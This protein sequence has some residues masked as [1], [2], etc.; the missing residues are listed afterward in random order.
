MYK[1]RIKDTVATYTKWPEECTASSHSYPALRS[2]THIHRDLH[3]HVTGYSYAFDDD[4]H[5]AT[6]IREAFNYRHEAAKAATR[7]KLSGHLPPAD[8]TATKLP[9]D[10]TE[11]RSP[12][13]HTE[14]APNKDLG[15]KWPVGVYLV[16][17]APY[18]A[19]VNA[20]EAST[21]MSAALR[22]VYPGRTPHFHLNTTE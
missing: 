7:T 18:L 10:L 2:L 19:N 20:A 1:A 17:S 3:L 5:L 4:T 21:K 14:T 22:V 12:Y 8:R 9:A 6:S 13:Q 16:A 11:F 15:T